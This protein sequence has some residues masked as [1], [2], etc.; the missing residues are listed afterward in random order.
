MSEDTVQADK[1]F[2]K[3]IILFLIIVTLAIMVAEPYLRDYLDQ[4]EQQSQKEPEMAFYKIMV[5]LKF[6]MGSVFL[7]LLGMGIYLILLARRI[8]RSHQYP[9]PGMK[10]IRD[11]RIRTGAEAKSITILMIVSSAVLILFAFLFLCFPWAF[12]KVLIKERDPEEIKRNI[13]IEKGY[14]QLR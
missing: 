1:E 11:T 8:S 3:K 9:P 5:V 7:L 2:R 10:V 13:G 6:L 14:D 4:I 12:E